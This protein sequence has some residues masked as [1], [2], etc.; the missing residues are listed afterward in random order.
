VKARIIALTL[1]AAIAQPSL[2]VV[3]AHASEVGDKAINDLLGCY[4]D[5]IKSTDNLPR[6]E[7]DKARALSIKLNGKAATADVIKTIMIRFYDAKR[8]GEALHQ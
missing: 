2:G 1:A 7:C 5:V 4:S 8:Q 3:T 6:H